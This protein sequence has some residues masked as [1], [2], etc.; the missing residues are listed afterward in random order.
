MNLSTVRKLC[1]LLGHGSALASRVLS[2]F[3]LGVLDVTL[4]TPDSFFAFVIAEVDLVPCSV[5]AALLGLHIHP[6]LVDPGVLRP[7]LGVFG[8]LAE[9]GVDRVVELLLDAPDLHRLLVHGD[10]GLGEQLLGLGRRLVSQVGTRDALV[11]LVVQGLRMLLQAR[12]LGLLPGLGEHVCTRS[13][14]LRSDV[15]LHVAGDGCGVSRRVVVVSVKASHV[16]LGVLRSL[17]S[18]L[19]IKTARKLFKVILA[20]FLLR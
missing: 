12:S 19:V 5:L 14:A 1:P 7:L 20:A 18:V 9:V 10:I 4:V 2:L 6:L 15:V 13:E 17:R 8:S 3:A 16:I 11:L